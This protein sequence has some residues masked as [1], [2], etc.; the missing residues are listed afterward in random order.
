MKHTSPLV[1][2]YCLTYNHSNFIRDAL[3]SF[4]MQKT[5]FPFEVIVYDDCSTDGN[6]DIIKGYIERYPD[7]IQAFLSDENHFKQGHTGFGFA[8]TS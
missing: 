2:I 1:S 3:D 5:N 8:K 6:Q 4:L 7:K